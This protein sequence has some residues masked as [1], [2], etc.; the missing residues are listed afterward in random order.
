MCACVYFHEKIQ[1]VN[2]KKS[3]W[4]IAKIFGSFCAHSDVRDAANA[5]DTISM[6][7]CSRMNLKKKNNHNAEMSRSTEN[8]SVNNCKRQLFVALRL[9]QIDRS[10]YETKKRYE[11]NDIFMN[12]IRNKS[13]SVRWMGIL[14]I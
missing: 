2:V 13:V 11:S 3:E 6:R 1:N 4:F 5:I 7:F 14:V 9:Y 8:K 10:H 12:E